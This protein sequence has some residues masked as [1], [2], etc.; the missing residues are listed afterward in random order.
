[1]WRVQETRLLAEGCIDVHALREGLRARGD[2]RGTTVAR[3]RSVGAEQAEAAA[4]AVRAIRRK[5]GRE[6][7]FGRSK[8]EIAAEA[9]WRAEILAELRRLNASLSAL[10]PVLNAI[11]GGVLVGAPFLAAP[12][13]T[14][15]D[16]EPEK[17]NG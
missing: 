15:A 2:H 11:A 14:L 4:Q 13:L 1:M 10:P 9:E 7:I 16:F 3:S 17:N 6:V 12:P 5:G 8:A